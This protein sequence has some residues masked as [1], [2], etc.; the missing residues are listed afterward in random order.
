MLSTPSVEIAEDS[1]GQDMCPDSCRGGGRGGWGPMEYSGPV[2]AQP[3]REPEENRGRNERR[4]CSQL[5]TTCCYARFWGG[6]VFGKTPWINH[7]DGHRGKK[8]SFPK[9][10]SSTEHLQNLHRAFT[11]N[12]MTREGKILVPELWK[13][14]PFKGATSMGI[15]HVYPLLPGLF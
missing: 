12:D 9:M 14:G 11:R 6:G 13:I 3:G 4:R 7:E 8:Y 1:E 5:L 2:S 15:Q 10:L